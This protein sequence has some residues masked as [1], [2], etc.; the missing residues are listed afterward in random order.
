MKIKLM[1]LLVG[2]LV[3]ALSL[4]PLAAQACTE[5][6]RSSDTNTDSTPR[7]EQNS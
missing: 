2:A 5:G 4:A 3:F 6:K 7:Q 1:P